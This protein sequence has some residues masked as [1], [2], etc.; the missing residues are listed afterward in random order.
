MAVFKRVS[1]QWRG[2]IS[3]RNTNRSIH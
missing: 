1:R 3:A 2:C